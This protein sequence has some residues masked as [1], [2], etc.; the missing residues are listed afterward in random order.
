MLSDDRAVPP[1]GFLASLLATIARWR[2]ADPEPP[3]QWTPPRG[4]AEL[5][6]LLDKVRAASAKLVG[7]IPRDAAGYSLRPAADVAGG[8]IGILACLLASEAEDIRTVP[9]YAWAI[10]EATINAALAIRQPT[11]S[12]DA[13]LVRRIVGADGRLGP[14]TGRWASTQQAWTWQHRRCAELLYARRAAPNIVAHGATQWLDCRT[15]SV[16]HAKKPA[17]N[18]PTE[19]IVARRYDAK[20]K[21]IGPVVDATGE[22]VLDP[23]VLMLFGPEGEP[24]GRAL[25][26]VRDG[27]VRWHQS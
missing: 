5:G 15:Q 22:V 25:D 8:S 24:Y 4:L 16:M 10:G 13:A 19:M 9:Q 3:Q 23:Y 18:P 11:E 12:F 2:A 17:T 20:A 27:R 1:T 21:W 26:V 6:P 7:V 14:Q